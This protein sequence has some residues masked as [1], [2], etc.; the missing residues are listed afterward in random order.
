MIWNAYPYT[1]FHD[2]NLDWIILTLKDVKNKLE[3]FVTTNSI[4]YS[5][6]FQWNIMNQYEKNT[7]TI[8]AQSGVAYLSVRAVPSGVAITNTSYWTP[9]FDLSQLF[10]DFN[11]NL[12][13]HDEGQNVTSSAAY[14]VDDLIIWKNI[15][16]KAI[17]PISIGDGFAVGT[18]IEI[19]TV[20]DLIKSLQSAVDSQ[21][22]L[23]DNNIAAINLINEKIDNV[24]IVNVKDFGA[25]GDGATNDTQAFIDALA[26]GKTIYVPTG[27]YYIA[28][29]L[30]INISGFTLFGDGVGKTK[31]RGTGSSDF[32]NFNAATYMHV[33][34][35][36]IENF[37]NAIELSNNSAWGLF[38]NIRIANCTRGIYA[39]GVYF[40]TPVNDVIQMRFNDITLN[41]CSY[42]IHLYCIGD[43][44]F[45]GCFVQSSSMGTGILIDAGVSAVYMTNCNFAGNNV[46]GQI[47]ALTMPGSYDGQR[48]VEPHNIFVEGS[49]FDS[50]NYTMIIKDAFDVHF[51]DCW[52]AG[53]QHSGVQIESDNVKSITFIGCRIHSNAQHGVWMITNGS[54]TT[55]YITISNCDIYQNTLRGADINKCR[56]VNVNG[57]NFHDN[58]VGSINVDSDCF[59]I[60]VSGNQLADLTQFTGADAERR[61]YGFINV[62]IANNNSDGLS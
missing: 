54:L 60:T 10:V 35:L 45:N 51:M 3:D 27:T 39:H 31:I 33:H 57:S 38:E 36:N 52:F 28:S 2:M 44:W 9:V 37:T 34:D 24:S 16:Y 30:L 6:P 50:S 32:L 23:I 8:D 19:V 5:N 42:G 22:L 13:E 21:Q 17:A 41:D 15:L 56:F 11:K 48:P 43:F 7:L 1:D 59:D 55:N 14:S 61:V 25:V 40:P 4:K 26:T 62:P 53:S 49:L 46:A 47:A 20:E 58:T 12:T 18:N 29:E